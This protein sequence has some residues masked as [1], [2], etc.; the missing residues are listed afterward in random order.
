MST[1]PYVLSLFTA[2]PPKPDTGAAVPEH[3]YDPAQQVVVDST[4]APV[5]GSLP[6]CIMAGAAGYMGVPEKVDPMGGVTSLW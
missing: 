4:G 1:K 3:R 5:M 2:L 6:T